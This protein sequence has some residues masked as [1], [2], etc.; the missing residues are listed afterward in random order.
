M[1]RYVLF[2]GNP[3]PL[4]RA[5]WAKSFENLKQAG[6]IHRWDVWM[7]YAV[8]ESAKS[9]QKNAGEAQGLQNP[10]ASP[11]AISP[12]GVEAYL[13]IVGRGKLDGIRTIAL[14]LL[15]R[16]DESGSF[17]SV[18]R[19]TAFQDCALVVLTKLIETQP[20]LVVFPVTPHEFADYMAWKL[21]ELLGIETL[22]FQ[23]CPVAPTVFPMKNNFQPIDVRSASVKGSAV[24]TR[25][26]EMARSNLQRLV[27]SDEPVYITDQRGAH[28]RANSISG[29]IRALRW[30]IMNLRWP[31]RSR[32]INFSGLTLRR[33]LLL[34]FLGFYLKS[35]L[36]KSLRRSEAIT[37]ELDSQV[38]R[39][40]L[41]LL[42]YEP[43][44]TSTPEGGKGTQLESIL[45]AR[46]LLRPNEALVVKE[47]SS[48]LSSSLKGYVSR[49]P[50]IYRLIERIPGVFRVS[51]NQSSKR[52]LSGASGV[53]TGSG[54][55][56]LEAVLQG[57]PVGYFG[58]PWWSGCPGTELITDLS[59]SNPFDIEVPTMD[60]VFE[61][62]L[63]KIMVRSI[64]GIGS[65]E[66]PVVEHRQGELPPGL[67]DCE[68]SALEQV[69]AGHFDNVGKRS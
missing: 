12:E 16:F 45:L 69:I 57:I 31:R 27:L 49:D 6:V 30:T 11:T 41:L 37:L 61:Y 7:P 60:E 65:E 14:R 53:F 66:W 67:F 24:A 28:S 47:H 15:D 21:S 58:H 20:D 23:P 36:Q 56:G 44:R 59:G 51:A 40:A 29:K 39:Y 50:G 34:R 22:F 25:V 52:W 62:L 43:E 26:L 13:R 54:T 18:D 2:V 64:P 9:L 19:E 35:S 46:A 68:V 4:G 17:R 32:E 3:A 8:S 63:D 42:H 38:N 10:S 33:G 5:T 1:T 55:A 48:Q